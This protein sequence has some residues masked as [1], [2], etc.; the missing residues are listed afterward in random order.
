[1]TYDE[2]KK[3]K[4]VIQKELEKLIIKKQSEGESTSIQEEIDS[5]FGLLSK[6]NPN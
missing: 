2:R 1:M 3:A 4:G 6:I 5:L